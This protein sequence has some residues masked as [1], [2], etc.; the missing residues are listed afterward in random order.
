VTVLW[1]LGDSWSDPRSY[2]SE[3]Y[4]AA[5]GFPQAVA[6]RLGAG[7]INSA[8]AGSGY[9]AT[10]GRPT[11]PEQAAQ[12]WGAAASA[13]LVF[14]GLN[15]EWQGH[16]PTETHE[17]AVT[18]YGLIRRLLPDAPLMV[19]GPQWGAQPHPADLPAYTDAIRTAA[20]GAGAAHV[21]PS[22]WLLDRYD[23][24][25]DPYHPNQA[26]HALIADLLAPEVLF[27]LA[28]RRLPARESWGDEGGWAAPWCPEDAAVTC[29]GPL[30]PSPV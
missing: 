4:G 9:A 23:L 5:A 25:Y 20:L 10:A 29:R 1:W 2:A 14:G 13:V 7:I 15:D 27:T 3:N 17:G 11:F 28:D 22:S 18:C 26:G 30:L 12:G 21:D 6:A 8:V 16:T 19:A 24:L